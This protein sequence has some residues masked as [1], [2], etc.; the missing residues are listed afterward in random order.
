MSIAT[1]LRVDAATTTRRRPVGLVRTKLDIAGVLVGVALAAVLPFAFQSASLLGFLA[2]MWIW[3]VVNIAWNVTL[4]YAG[5]LSFGQLAFFGVGAYTSA[6]LSVHL[7]VPPWLDTV[8]A[9]VAGGLAALL[10]G[11]AV[12]RLRGVYVALV[13]LA[14]HE[15]LMTMIS[16]DTGGFTGGPNG[17][18]PVRPYIATYNLLLQ[19]AFGYWIGLAAVLLVA[20]AGILLVRSPVGLALVAAR[21]AENVAR[22]RGVRVT[23]YR[24]VAFVFSGSVAGFG[25]ALYGHYNGVVSPDIFNFGIVM[26]LLAMIIVGGWGT[27]WGPIVGTIA[28]TVVVYYV[29]GIW[30]G[31]ENAVAG[32]IM[33][34][35][36]LFL[37]GGLI[38]A[39]EGVTARGIRKRLWREPADAQ[40]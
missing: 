27:V 34:V 18:G 33:V 25:G 38:G 1:A 2:V 7:K 29:Q 28:I 16:G 13:T 37:R 40:R 22:A 19:S 9:L 4:G 14:F 36:I 11:V 23:R 32:V 17:L 24:L 5:I 39:A 10:V 12:L 3:I 20:I 15:L 6:I 8:A 26:T 21:D 31:Y 35:A 30:A